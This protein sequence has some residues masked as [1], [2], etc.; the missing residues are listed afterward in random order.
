MMMTFFVLS[1]TKPSLPMYTCLGLVLSTFRA[2]LA[3]L[4]AKECD[5]VD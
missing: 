5:G 2:L 3:T 4:H 1:E